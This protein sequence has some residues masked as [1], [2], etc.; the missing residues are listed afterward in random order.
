MGLIA[1]AHRPK[2]SD[3]LWQTVQ[4]VMDEEEYGN[5]EM[6]LRHMARE[7]GYDV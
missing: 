7:G 1:M 2:L 6:A 4:E 5:A 3:Q